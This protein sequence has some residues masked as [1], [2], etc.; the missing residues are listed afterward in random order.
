[1]APGFNVSAPVMIPDSDLTNHSSSAVQDLGGNAFVDTFNSQNVS[2][3]LESED[4]D[5][6]MTDA[7]MISIKDKASLDEAWLL[8]HIQSDI[9]DFEDLKKTVAFLEHHLNKHADIHIVKSSELEDADKVLKEVDVKVIKF[10]E[11]E[12][13]SLKSQIPKL[14]H[15]FDN[16][17]MDEISLIVENA[18]MFL[19]LS[20]EKIEEL[21]MLEQEWEVAEESA[22]IQKAIHQDEMWEHSKQLLIE[23]LEP[24]VSDELKKKLSDHDD[25]NKLPNAYPTSKPGGIKINLDKSGSEASS[26]FKKIKKSRMHI[27]DK[28]KPKSDLSET[29]LF[30]DLAS[31]EG[32]VNEAFKD[33]YAH[34]DDDPDNAIEGFRIEGERLQ[35]SNEDSRITALNQA[36]EKLKRELESDHKGRKDVTDPVENYSKEVQEALKS[37]KEASHEFIDKKLH[38]RGAHEGKTEAVSYLQI[39]LIMF[40]CIVF[41]V[42]IF[43]FKTL[44]R[45]KMTTVSFQNLSGVGGCDR[46]YMELESVKE[47]DGW[48]KAWSPWTSH[49]KKQ[50]KFK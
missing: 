44:V 49:K 21:E 20:M 45:R 9:E 48:G 7:D 16:Q 34:D 50:N 17:S 4:R 24:S 41:L 38:H 23:A 1:M 29:K 26:M 11:Q 32:I 36:E 42:T 13:L 18:E 5:E 27:N 39:L 28:K 14:K 35:E 37:A 40:C 25:S 30:D 43:A 10:Y 3:H 12:L 46:S 15:K 19:Q 6:E 33:G 2:L 22:E 31:D 8:A 47:D